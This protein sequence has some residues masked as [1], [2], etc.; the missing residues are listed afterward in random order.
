MKILFTDLDGTLLNDESHISEY[1][2]DVL[3]R[4]VE[5]GH[6]LVLS[7]GRPFESMMQVVENDGLNTEGL[8]ILASNGAVIYDCDKK[9][10]IDEKTVTIDMVKKVWKMC[11]DRDIHVQT[12]EDSNILTPFL[13][14]EIKWYTKRIKFNIV[15]TDTPWEEL[16]REPYKLLAIDLENKER[17]EELRK[18]IVNEFG[19][20]VGSFFSSDAYLEVVNKG[21]SKG[22]GLVWLCNHLGID[23]KDSFGAGDAMNDLSMLEAAGVGIAMFNGDKE[24]FNCADII[25]DKSNDEDGLARVIEKYILG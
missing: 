17:L 13:D 1:T 9:K 22:N 14:D 16:S 20:E 18:D 8:Y 15:C 19:Y 6:K 23:I 24:L 11:R 2:K 21:A 4:M 12:Y 25:T 10:I 5:A 3:K 7:S